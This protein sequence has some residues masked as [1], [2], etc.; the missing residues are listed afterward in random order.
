[1]ATSMASLRRE[2]L[3]EKANSTVGTDTPAAAAM[4]V[5]VVPA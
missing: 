3:V 1:M 2:A 4:E 5:M